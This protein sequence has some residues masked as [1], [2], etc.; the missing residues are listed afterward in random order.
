MPYRKAYFLGVP[1]LFIFT[2]IWTAQIAEELQE[3]VAELQIESPH[4]S[5]RHSE[6]EKDAVPPLHIRLIH[7]VPSGQRSGG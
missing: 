1:T 2:L 5:W 3:K 6:A 7:A 4:T